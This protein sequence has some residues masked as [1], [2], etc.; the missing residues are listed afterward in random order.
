MLTKQDLEKI[1]KGKNIFRIC[2]LDGYVVFVCHK[3]ELNI[4]KIVNIHNYS[5]GTI[6][7]YMLIKEADFQDNYIKSHYLRSS[8][9]SK[10]VKE[11]IEYIPYD[12]IKAIE[13]IIVKEDN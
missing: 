2:A 9:E 5:S 13:E 3:N 8:S 4:N 7:D 6:V 1:I 11:Y 12:R 10:S